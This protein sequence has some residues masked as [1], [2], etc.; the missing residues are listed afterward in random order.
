MPV[1]AIAAAIGVPRAHA[2]RLV[3]QLRARSE[4]GIRIQLL[5]GSA[6]LVTAPENVDVIHRFLGTSKPPSLSR[7]A[8]ETLTIVAYRQP[9]TRPEIE[10]VRG[11]NSD[12]AVQTLV[13]REL[14]EEAG[15]RATLGR[16]TE[17]KTTF[18]FLEY[19]GLGSLDDL[20]ALPG[21]SSDQ[22]EL[23]DLGLRSPGGTPEEGDRVALDRPLT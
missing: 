23:I 13:A 3:E 7:S 5:E 4:G 15:R 14:I 9:V 18:A 19:F 11:V 10:A 6:Q 8:L 1:Q 21:P 20:P 16:P 22:P 17:Y 12:R 2:T